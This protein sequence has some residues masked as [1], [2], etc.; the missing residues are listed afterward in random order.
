MKRARPARHADTVALE[1]VLEDLD[2]VFQ[3]H[4]QAVAEVGAV[5]VLLHAVGAAVKAAL[6]PAG[7]VEHGLAKRLGGD[8]AGMDRDA[9]DAAPV[10][11]HQNRFA[12]LRTLDGGAAAGGSATD[13]DEIVGFHRQIPLPERSR[14]YANRGMTAVCQLRA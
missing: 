14:S 4:R 10:L 1:L 7:E 13:D 9:A 8:R 3:S 6:A 2:L 11:H 12:E 5:D